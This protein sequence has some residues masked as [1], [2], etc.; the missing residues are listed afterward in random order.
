MVAHYGFRLIPCA[1]LAS[2]FSSGLFRNKHKA[3]GNGDLFPSVSLF[4]CKISPVQLVPWRI[5]GQS[6]LQGEVLLP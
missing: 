5:A 3:S 4:C 6:F 2:C 1:M